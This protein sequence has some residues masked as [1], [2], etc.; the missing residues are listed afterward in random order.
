MSRHAE[1]TDAHLR[2]VLKALTIYGQQETLTAAALYSVRL[3]HRWLFFFISR[4]DV[5]AQQSNG[6]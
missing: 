6:K 1:S 5:P 3:L 4:C 2:H